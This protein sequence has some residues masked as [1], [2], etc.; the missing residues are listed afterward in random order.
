MTD[1]LSL[2]QALRTTGAVRAFRAEPVDD[3]V[4]FRILD[5]ARFAP[6]GGNRQGWRVVV[7]KDPNTRA[8]LRELYRPGWREYLAL[9]EA[10]LVPFA[11]ITDDVREA[12]V[13]DGLGPI[14]DEPLGLLADSL[15]EAPVVLVL[16]AD[17]RRLAAVD[18]QLARYTMAGGA[19]I[20]PFAWNV[21]LA[22]RAEGLSG[23][24]TTM[25]IRRES[26]VKHLLGIP[27]ELIVAGVI[28][29]G[30]PEHQVQRLSRS[31]V[32]SFATVDRYDGAP[33][34][35]RADADTGS[36]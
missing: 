25:N 11:P 9:A 31:E 4:L 7:V 14:G 5:T 2:V 16:L 27:D 21:L 6:S 28:V 35:V 22:A 18:K 1:D 32:E 36:Q 12:E 15:H 20:Y 30:R 10:G 17:L 19:S 26:D 24:I 23:V 8:R 34:V 29:L 3:T 13:L 33:F